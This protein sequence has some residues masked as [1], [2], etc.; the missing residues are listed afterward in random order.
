M[1][2]NTHD[3]DCML[4]KQPIMKERADVHIGYVLFLGLFLLILCAC[5]IVREDST[6]LNYEEYGNANGNNEWEEFFGSD[7]TLPA[8]PDAYANYW[9]FSFKPADPNMGIRIRGEFG[10]FRYMNYTIYDVDTR[11]CVGVIKDVEIETDNDN[12]NPFIDPEIENGTHYTIHLIPEVHEDCDL[13]NKMIYDHS[14]NGL[15]LCLRYYD[16]IQDNYGGVG[17]PQLEAF[18][19]ISSS[20]LIFTC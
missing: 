4:R 3:G 13:I 10:D 15:S 14:S 5:D 1:I 6:P 8:F 2:G 17:L 11:K 7:T 18:N 16:P 9:I 20:N 19:I 12:Y